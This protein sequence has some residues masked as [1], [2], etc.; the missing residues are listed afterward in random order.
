MAAPADFVRGR[1]DAISAEARRALWSAA[2]PAPSSPSVYPTTEDVARTVDLVAEHCSAQDAA[3]VARTIEQIR[4]VFHELGKGKEVF[5]ILHAD[6]HQENYF[7]QHGTPRVIDFDDCGWG[8]YLFDF[9]VT[10]RELAH[11]PTY[12]LLRE[13][14]LRGYRTTRPFPAQ[15]EAYLETFFALRRIQLMNKYLLIDNPRLLL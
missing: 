8:H 10:L 15:Q 11:L 9:T 13:A 3:I 7:F 12:P 5:G 4:A 14:L 1:V 2:T 6:L